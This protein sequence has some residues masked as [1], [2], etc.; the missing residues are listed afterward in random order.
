MLQNIVTIYRFN[1]PFLN[2]ESEKDKIIK[3]KDKISK[4]IEN[5]LWEWKKTKEEKWN[6]IKFKFDWNIIKISFSYIKNFDWNYYIPIFKM[7]IHIDNNYIKSN[8]EKRKIVDFLTSLFENF[9]WINEK[10]YLIDID[11]NLFYEYW[12]LRKN[13]YPIYQFSDIYKIQTD[14]EKWNG[15][16]VLEKFIE[17]FQNWNYI[18]T[19]DN[20]KEYHEMHKII[21]YYIYLVYIMYKNIEK[22]AE[23]LKTL[24]NIWYEE[25][26]FESEK[27]LI[28][29][30][31]SYVQWLNIDNFKAYYT[32]LETLFWLIK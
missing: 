12:I 26:E 28:Q 7:N 29:K 27:I 14:F 6:Y 25:I 16:K 18:L 23:S 8:K 2:I 24:E 30:R 11:V 13:K 21:L 31:L 1:T 5:D 17:K 32:K 19:K 3:I 15:E 9:D 20:A 22:S 10:E 4:F